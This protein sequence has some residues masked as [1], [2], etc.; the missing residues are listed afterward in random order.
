MCSN[1][2]AGQTYDYIIVGSGAGGVPLADRLT[3]AGHTVLLIEK[4]PPS[5][6][7]WG[8][9][10][11]PD[12]L[13]QTSLTRFD[14]PGLANEIWHNPTGVVCTDVD[15]MAGCVLGGGTAVNSG[16]WWKPH[17]LD[18][19]YLWPEGWKS[20]DLAGATNRVF[21]RIPGTTVP[22]TDGKL[23][24]QQGFDV[25]T[26]GLDASGWK[27]ITPNDHPDQKN[28]MSLG[29]FKFYICISSTVMRL[30]WL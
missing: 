25:L 7:I 4:G 23:Y 27:S 18:W 20:Q 13:N 17:P 19:D 29:L 11:K 24:L 15:Q 21:E 22:S 6:G 3:A 16:L 1:V 12:W 9:A 28:R 26:S 30:S 5:T 8:G 2:T 10:L 14:V